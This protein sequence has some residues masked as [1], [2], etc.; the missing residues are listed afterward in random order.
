M[1]T[2]AKIESNRRRFGA[3]MRPTQAS[4]ARARPERSSPWQNAHWAIASPTCRPRA[5]VSGSLFTLS[6]AGLGA[7]VRS[8]R[9][10]LT[11]ST[12]SQSPASVSPAIDAAFRAV[13]AVIL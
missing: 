13:R 3:Q 6:P 2:L 10:S 4:S 5:T 9:S 8:R 11:A 7:Q 12:P 1:T